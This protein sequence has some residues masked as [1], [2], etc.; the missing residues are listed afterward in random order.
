MI[1]KILVTL[2]LTID[3]D[4]LKNQFIL[5]EKYIYARCMYRYAKKIIYEKLWKVSKKENCLEYQFLRLTKL[6]NKKNINYI[7][8]KYMRACQHA[9]K[10]IYI[11]IKKL[12]NVSK[13]IKLVSSLYFKINKD[14]SCLNFFFTLLQ[15]NI[16]NSGTWIQGTLSTSHTSREITNKES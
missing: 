9:K 15:F 8:K 13:K 1:K 5:T 16:Q 10:I 11:Y 7:Y 3:K 12:W 2:R 4:W 14:S 6:I